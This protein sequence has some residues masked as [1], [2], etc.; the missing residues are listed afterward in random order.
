MPNFPDEGQTEKSAMK[1]WR[2][3]WQR[4]ALVLVALITLIAGIGVWLSTSTSGLKSL[5]SAVSHISGDNLSFEG[6]DGVLF[7]SISART[8]RF[9]S[10]DLIVIARDVQLNWQPDELRSGHV[11]ITALSAKEVEI[12]SPPSSQPKSMPT[13]LELPFSLSLHKLD[14]GTLHVMNEE[15]GK[16]VF[17][18][19][20][21]TAGLESNGRRHQL[22]GLRTNLEFG[23]LIASGQLDGIRP[24]ALHAEAELAEL[25]NSD[26]PALETTGSRISA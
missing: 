11:A 24:F 14:V 15:G 3:R 1:K 26:F 9:A 18:A 10:D 12:V 16:P 21:L 2:W 7:G 8:I 20:E 19:A 5:A 13:N 23:R 4:I 22:S 6:L 17:I 25:V